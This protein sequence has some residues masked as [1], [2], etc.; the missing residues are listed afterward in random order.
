MPFYLFPLILLSSLLHGL[1]IEVMK[2]DERGFHPRA[3]LLPYPPER[4]EFPQKESGIEVVSHG[5]EIIIVR[6]SDVGLSF[7]ASI[8]REWETINIIPVHESSPAVLVWNH[9]TRTVRESSVIHHRST[10]SHEAG[11]YLSAIVA[12][13]PVDSFFMEPSR[14][15]YDIKPL[16]RGIGVWTSSERIIDV[17][18]FQAENAFAI[19]ISPSVSLGDL[20]SVQSQQSA[21]T[22]KL[23]ISVPDE[24]ASII[25]FAVPMYALLA[26]PGIVKTVMR[27]DGLHVSALTPGE[28]TFIILSGTGAT[29]IVQFGVGGSPREYYLEN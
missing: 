23:S 25:K 11:V 12:D 27:H 14:A 16:P 28:G 13:A 3:I 15:G 26:P 1:D 29:V 21:R 10:V 2:T 8:N 17:P 20:I 4:I 24:G 9:E 19:R 6:K 22:Q 7:R 18:C 5:T